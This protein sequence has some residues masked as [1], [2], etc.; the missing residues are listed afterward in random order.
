MEAF[1]DV[2]DPD[3]DDVEQRAS[4]QCGV[5]RRSWSSTKSS[6]RTTTPSSR[7]PSL[8]RSAATSTLGC[9]K[10]PL[11]G[12]GYGYRVAKVRQLGANFALLS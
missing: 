7:T 9:D 2:V 11:G 4:D 5:E 12:Y 3:E 1:V 10:P 8:V 6:G